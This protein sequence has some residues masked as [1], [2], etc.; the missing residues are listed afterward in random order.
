MESSE[1]VAGALRTGEP[2]EGCFPEAFLAHGQLGA[3]DARAAGR[4]HSPHSSSVSAIAANCAGILSKAGPIAALHFLNARTRF[5]FTGVYVADP[6]LLR[7]VYLYDRENP[8]LNVS[9]SVAR[10]DETFCAIVLSSGR[11]F[12]TADATTDARTATH[13]TRERVLSYYG[14]PIRGDDGRTWGSLCHFDVRPRLL[15]PWEMGV[16][17][18]VVSLFGRV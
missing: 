4:S 6:P 17:E 12:S 9:G 10:L 13:A 5:R 7:N 3:D 1:S 8:A 14:V 16:L 15:P 11:P 2:Q 18:A